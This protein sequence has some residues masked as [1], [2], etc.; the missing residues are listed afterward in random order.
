MNL[1]KMQPT[2]TTAS[3]VSFRLI[4]SECGVSVD[5][6]A[7]LCDLDDKPGTYYC[8]T[9][10]DMLK[11]EANANSNPVGIIKRFC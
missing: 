10:A 5:S 8:P 9:C 6:R 4:C 3:G 11:S 1:Q 7:V 2:P